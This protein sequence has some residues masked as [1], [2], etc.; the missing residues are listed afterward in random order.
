VVDG[1][2]NFGFQ[3]EIR[4]LGTGALNTTWGQASRSA[5]VQHFISKNGTWNG[6]T[7]AFDPGYA[8]LACAVNYATSR[9]A[10]DRVM[11]SHGW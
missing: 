1:I 9:D 5:R 11:L 2:W 6:Y 4:L 3:Q 7:Q 10:R 8:D